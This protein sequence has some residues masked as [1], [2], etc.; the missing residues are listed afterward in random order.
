MKKPSRRI[1]IVDDEPLVGESLSEVLRKWN[2][3]VTFTSES[4]NAVAKLTAGFDLILTDI[5]MPDVTGMELLEKAKQLSPATGVILMTAYGTIEQ[6]VEALK[7]GAFDYLTKPF[8]L[9]RV[10]EMLAQYFAARNG[11]PAPRTQDSGTPVEFVGQSP[12]L[13]ALR[14]SVELASQSDAPVLIESESGT[15]KELVAA[16][17]HYNSPRKNQPY[18]RI[19]CAALPENLVE[20]Q[21]FGHERGAFTGAFRTF[22]GV[23]EEAREGTVLLDEITE[24]PVHLQAKLLRVLQEGEFTRVGSTQ[25]LQTDARII[26]TSNR[27]VQE[28]IREGQFRQDLFFRLNVIAIRIPPLRER[29]EDLPLLC[30]HFVTKYAQKYGRTVAGLDPETLARLQAYD[31]P[32][33]VRELENVIHRCVLACQ[34][35]ERITP[36]RLQQH[37]SFPQTAD[38]AQLK[39]DSDLSLEEMEKR[40]I[41]VT[42]ERHNFHKTRTAS[43]LGITLKTLRNKMLQYGI[44]TPP[45]S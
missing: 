13:Q 35:G 16:E 40:L 7:I 19:N 8:D 1:L 11:D 36:R 17:I 29:K 10:K 15:G 45:R 26:A 5:R 2:Y 18:L 24:M 21:L 3:E 39:F 30:E 14:H 31:W 33:N 44:E 23:F 6:A 28:A 42:L 27:D 20:S 12:S 41:Q 38:P 9:Q 34:N 22:R 43:V 37:A 25:T 4:Q 32:G